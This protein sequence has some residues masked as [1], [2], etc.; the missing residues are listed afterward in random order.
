MHGPDSTSAGGIAAGGMVGIAGK[1]IADHF[2]V[3]SGAALPRPF[4]GLQHQY[5]GPLHPGDEIVNVSIDGVLPSSQIVDAVAD[6]LGV[7]QL[8]TQSGGPFL[9]VA[10]FGEF[11]S[12]EALLVAASTG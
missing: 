1:T 12:V 9:E 8:S 3:R 4:E 2:G 10:S 5:T 7:S 11:E 6:L